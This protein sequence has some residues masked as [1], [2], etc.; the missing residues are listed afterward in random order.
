M[1]LARVISSFLCLHK[2]PNLTGAA[3]TLAQV[4]GRAATA[5]TPGFYAVP[6]PMLWQNNCVNNVTTTRVL[7]PLSLVGSQW[8]QRKI[9]PLL[10][11]LSGRNS[12]RER[13]SQLHPPLS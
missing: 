1:Q 3:S 13:K 6:C 7:R 5:Y 8:Q 2:A 9:F 11:C 10:A 12:S 4:L